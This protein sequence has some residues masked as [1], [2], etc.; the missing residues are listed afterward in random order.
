MRKAC[1][2]RQPCGCWRRMGASWP[3]R[4]TGARHLRGRAAA[5]RGRGDGAARADVRRVDHRSRRAGLQEQARV[6][7][8]EID[9]VTSS[10]ARPCAW[11]ARASSWPRSAP[12][13]ESCPTCSCCSTSM[14]ARGLELRPTRG[15]GTRWSAWPATSS[16]R[17][18][19][20]ANARR[21]DGT[22]WLL[23]EQRPRPRPL[24]PRRPRRRRG[25]S[26]RSRR[27]DRPVARLGG[28]GGGLHP[29]MGGVCVEELAKDYYS[30]R[31][32]GSTARPGRVAARQ[33]RY[34]APWRSGS[35]ADPGST[36]SICCRPWRPGRASRSAASA[37]PAADPGHSSG[38]RR[39]RSA[40][41][42]TATR[43]PLRSPA[44]ICEAEGPF[45]RRPAC[46]TRAA[47]DRAA[48]RMACSARTAAIT[49]PAGV[50]TPP[51]S[52]G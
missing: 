7:F 48:R 36:T 9:G 5:H 12:T 14:R 26:P 3:S 24:G 51:R 31:R 42:R 18:D 21:A 47:P 52:V 22:G 38:R 46:G 29:A 32:P 37:A 17:N 19:H 23:D 49:P 15:R 25:R 1:R 10:T 8:D 45:P 13:P 2:D 6:P 27:D 40:A 35:S 41:A 28:A 39:R 33:Q 30:V 20:D 50:E 16:P 34:A 4:P 43:A 11:A 44:A